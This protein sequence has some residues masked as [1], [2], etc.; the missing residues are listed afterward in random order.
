MKSY[1]LEATYLVMRNCLSYRPRTHLQ[2]TCGYKIKKWNAMVLVLNEVENWK[3]MLCQKERK[4]IK[5]FL[6]KT[7]VPSFLVFGGFLA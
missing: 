2:E 5:G 4:M 7:S 6:L 3:V 1:K